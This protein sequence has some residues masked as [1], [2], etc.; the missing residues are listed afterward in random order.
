[1]LS[2]K[3]GSFCLPDLPGLGVDVETGLSLL[4]YFKTDY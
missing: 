1:M 4:N 2:Q 3:P